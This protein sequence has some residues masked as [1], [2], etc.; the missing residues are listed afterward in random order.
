MKLEAQ[1]LELET[2]DLGTDW[3]LDYETTEP[4]PEQADE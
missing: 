2:R 1:K 3:G 4:V